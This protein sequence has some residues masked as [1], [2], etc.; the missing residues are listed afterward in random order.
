MIR[1]CVAPD[2]SCLFT[3]VGFLVSKGEA[4][5]SDPAFYTTD[6]LGEGKA[7]VDE[8]CTWL[9]DAHTYGGGNELSILAKHFSLEIVVWNCIP[10][11]RPTASMLARYTPS[12]CP[13]TGT[14]HVLYTGQHYDAIVSEEG[15]RVF[16]GSEADDEAAL[17]ASQIKNARELELRTRKRKRLLCSCG[18]VCNTSE[19]WQTH[20][21]EAHSEDADFDFLCSEVEVEEV[22]ASEHEN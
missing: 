22:V 18:V 3:S 9:L 13:A 12:G 2:G 21:G 6:Q 10:F 19:E 7:S 17:L 1:K 14:I 4:I 20:C 5:K 11:S 16:C 8:Y 15:R